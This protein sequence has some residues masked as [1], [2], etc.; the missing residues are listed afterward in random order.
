MAVTSVMGEPLGVD[1]R[2]EVV[3]FGEMDCEVNGVDGA[4][5]A[6]GG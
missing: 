6:C 1:G 5:I 2:V 4:R 3:L